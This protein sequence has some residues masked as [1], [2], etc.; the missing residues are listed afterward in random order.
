MSVAH[1]N[2]IQIGEYFISSEILEGHIQASHVLHTLGGWQDSRI[3][4]RRM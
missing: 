4:E 2:Y 3:E 1:K